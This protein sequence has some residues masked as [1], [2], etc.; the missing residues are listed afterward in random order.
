M[1]DLTRAVFGA[2]LVALVSCGE[3]HPKDQEPLDR[4]GQH[5]AELNQLVLMFQEDRGLGAQ[6]ARTDIKDPIWVH[7]YA[8]GLAVSGSSE[9]YYY[10][11]KPQFDIVATLD[12]FTPRT[13]G[14]WLRHVEGLWYLYFDSEDEAR[15]G[16]RAA[17]NNQ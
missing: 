5:R 11:A 3:S 17:P 10:S 1:C 14:T 2:A 16:L 4:F 13:S 7:V 15:A 8:S 9:G 6:P 12:G